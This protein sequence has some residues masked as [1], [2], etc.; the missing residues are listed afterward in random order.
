M[1][2]KFGR[3]YKLVYTIPIVNPDG[4]ID[5][6]KGETIEIKS[7]LKCEFSIVRNTFQDANKAT[8]KVYNLNE[9]NRNKVFQDYLNI[10]RFVF[11]DFYAGYGEKMP[12]LFTGKVLKAYSAKQG[13][14]VITT[15][16]AIDSDIVQSYTTK[17]F[18]ATVT[19]EEV[20]K[21]L[22]EDMPNITLGAMAPMPEP[23]GNRLVV[24][25]NTFAAINALTG[26]CAF[27]DNGKLNILTNNQVVGDVAIYKLTSHDG[28][29]GTPRRQ[30]AQVEIDCVFSPEITVGQLIEVDS[31]TSPAQFNG[32][33]KVIGLR[34]QGSIGG[35]DCGKANTTLNLFVGTQ[36]PNSNYIFVSIESPTSEIVEVTGDKTKVISI[37]LFNMQMIRDIHREI[38]KTGK[39]PHKQLTKNIWW[40]EL[41]QNYGQQGSVPTIEV[42]SNL[43]GV[44]TQ[45]QGVLNQNYKGHK[46]TITSG[47]RSKSYNAKVGGAPKSYH[48]QGKAVDI[49]IQGLQANQTYPLFKSAW[50]GWSYCGNGFI[51]CDIRSFTTKG[52][53]NDI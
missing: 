41:I 25:G 32:Q 29:L 43:W 22:L 6:T 15:I 17:T 16:E 48:I 37:D 35:G 3:N 14:D 7:P 34:H 13:N 4:T 47:W 10:N 12:L 23:L 50:G 11:V 46:I 19:K 24:D 9:S 42:L 38:K 39:I 53:A 18:E 51:H 52:I 28:L 49:V 30:D 8:F 27:V 2:V 44:A 5:R 36:L 40:D 45:L 31:S 1:V 20:V 26:G 33:F 21:T